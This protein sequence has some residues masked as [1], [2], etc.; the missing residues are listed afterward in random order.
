[1]SQ[2]LFVGGIAYGTTQ[3]SLSDHFSTAGN[4]VSAN[5]IT[6][7]QTGRSKGF[8]FVEM[9]NTDEAQKA[10]EMFNGQELDG[11]K[12]AVNFARPK[13]DRPRRESRY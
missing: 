4:V 12:L 5:I 11:R 3:K 7:R 6:D 8:G 13:E 1:M 2:T 10:V 9:S